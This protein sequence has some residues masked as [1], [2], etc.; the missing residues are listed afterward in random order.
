MSSPASILVGHFDPNIP[1]LLPHDKMYKIQVGT[2]LFKISGASLSSDGPSYFTNYFSRRENTDSAGSAI[3]F[4]DSCP[5]SSASNSI[6]SSPSSSSNGKKSHDVLF[7]DRSSDIFELIYR[8]LQGYFID[9]NNE[10]D[11]TMLIADAMYY[12]LPRLRALLKESDYYFTNVGGK[13]FKIPKN[14]LNR[15]GDKANY[16][17]ITLETLYVDLDKLVIMRKLLRPPPHSSSYV[18]RSPEIFSILL[19][20]LSGSKLT[21]D[22]NKRESLMKECRYYRFLNLE[23]RLVKCEI[24]YNPIICRDE[25]RINLKDVSKK[26]LEIQSHRGNNLLNDIDSAES[27]ES[28]QSHVK[29]RKLSISDNSWTFCGYKR[30]YLD[31]KVCDLIVQVDSTECT[32]VVNLKKNIVHLD[33]IGET[34]KKFESIFSNFLLRETNVNINNYKLKGMSA[35]DG[36]GR[37]HLVIPAFTTACNFIVGENQHCNLK[38]LLKDTTDHC[39]VTDFSN[40]KTLGQCQGVNYYLTKSLWKISVKDGFLA[41]VVLRAE[42]FRNLEEFVAQTDFI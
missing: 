26:G 35:V 22:D 42:V 5:S 27:Q 34:A 17:Q 18:P 12:N 9:I 23:Q 3:T 14:L 24:K 30:P 7:I 16:F 6:N 10:L 40:L 13:S 29:K 39:E 28:N 2:K 37:D 20:L 25:I 8:H 21:L 31:D 36:N 32:L 15:D 41:L 38:T 11:Y 1:Q 33:I 19:Q 4:G